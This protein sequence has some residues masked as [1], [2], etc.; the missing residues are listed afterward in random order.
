MKRIILK[1]GDIISDAVKK[2][3][4]DN[5]T[6]VMP[7]Y[8]NNDVTMELTFNAGESMVDVCR[9]IPRSSTY[10][11]ELLLSTITDVIRP[12]GGT[13]EIISR[14]LLYTSC[15]RGNYTKLTD[16]KKLAADEIY[17]RD[18]ASLPDDGAL[19]AAH[20]IFM[21]VYEAVLK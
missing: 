4:A 16:F 14:A 21:Q 20:R 12:P 9:R 15:N 10:R 7:L 2:M 13:S 17:W 5:E 18:V 11:Y 1:Y 3:I 8:V 6:A 19:T